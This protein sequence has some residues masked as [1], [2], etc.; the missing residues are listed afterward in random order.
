MTAT[1]E[2]SALLYRLLLFTVTHMRT[3]RAY[4]LQSRPP[5]GAK[6][7]YVGGVTASQFCFRLGSKCFCA[8]T[9]RMLPSLKRL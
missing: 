4:A 9:T 7:A 1:E 5:C 3:R 2:W 8:S 6:T